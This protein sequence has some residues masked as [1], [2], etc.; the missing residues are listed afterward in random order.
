MPICLSSV[1]NCD[2]FAL[3]LLNLFWVFLSGH[4]RVVFSSYCGCFCIIFLD[5]LLSELFDK[6][7]HLAGN[8]RGF[9]LSS[10][11]F[12]NSDC[13]SSLSIYWCFVS[14]LHTVGQIPFFALVEFLLGDYFC[15][16]CAS[17]FR[18]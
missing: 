9:L 7:R 13:F 16:A 5:Y 18:F 14:M 1:G 6:Q 17:F 2:D 8:F 12:I 4:R 15:L 3:I 11:L 10:L